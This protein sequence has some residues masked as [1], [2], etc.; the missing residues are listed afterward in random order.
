LD[1]VWGAL[2]DYTNL[3]RFSPSILQSQVVERQGNRIR[4]KQETRARFLFFYRR[5]QM[6]IQ[7]TEHPF[8]RLD[9]EE[10]S[11]RDFELYQGFWGVSQ[12]AQGIILDYNTTA[13]ADFGPI[14]GWFAG[15]YVKQNARE[16][17]AYLKA[18]I[19]AR[20]KRRERKN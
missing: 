20:V 7:V 17:W 11:H 1:V 13:K 14:V 19:E 8:S 3:P 18:E 2:T 6:D 12:T 9:F 16:S 15:D 5:F 4:L 10:T